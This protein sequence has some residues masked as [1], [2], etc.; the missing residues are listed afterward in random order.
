MADVLT[1]SAREVGSQSY[2]EWGAVIAGATAALAVSL[3]LLN[4]GA[5]IGLASVS[6][7]TSTATGLKAVGVG[8]AFWMLLVTLWSFAL[9]GYLAGRLRHRWNDA[10][11]AEV[12]FRDSAH[13]LLVWCVAVLFAGILAAA[14]VSAV[15]RGLGTIAH[16]GAHSTSDPVTTTTD[17]LLRSNTSTLNKAQTSE[18]VDARGEISRL[19]LASA[20]DG[21]ISASDRTYLAQLVAARTGLSQADAEKRVFDTLDQ[22]KAGVDRA[23]KIAIVLGF[24]TASILLI[25]GAVAWWAAALG[26]KHR[27]EGTVWHGFSEIKGF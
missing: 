9:G 3:V 4:F 8:A 14:G 18:A 12:E 7:W 20:R 19:L 23:R 10:I 17:L 5:A 15:G 1:R 11:K 25:G 24:L 2:V 27:D 13:G 16:S 21:E 6:P 26:G 22:M